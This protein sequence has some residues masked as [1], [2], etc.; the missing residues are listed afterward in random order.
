M[1]KEKLREMKKAGKES[2][3]YKISKKKSNKEIEKQ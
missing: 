1:E 3:G 2:G